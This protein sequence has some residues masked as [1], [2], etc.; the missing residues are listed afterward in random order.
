MSLID[1]KYISFDIGED[2]HNF[3]FIGIQEYL[4]EKSNDY[5]CI[6]RNILQ[7]IYNCYSKLISLYGNINETSKQYMKKWTIKD[8]YRIHFN[9]ETIHFISYFGYGGE[10][11]R[12]GS[13]NYKK[14][15]KM[16]LPQISLEIKKA[17][18]FKQNIFKQT[19]IVHKKK[20]NK[21][22]DIAVGVIDLISKV[23]L[24]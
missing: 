18:K 4:K 20:P 15:V 22:E 13:N 2:Y 9:N 23:I 1:Q 16:T 24:L 12:Y 3:N 8:K 11:E 5:N 21:Y 6:Q 17:Q 19:K 7:E 14:I 10:Y